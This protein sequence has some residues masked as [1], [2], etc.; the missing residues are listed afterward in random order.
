MAF[1]QDPHAQLPAMPPPPGGIPNFDDPEFTVRSLI[2]SSI[3]F[4]SLAGVTVIVR[5]YT[6]TRIVRAFGSDD[7]EAS[8][9]SCRLEDPGW[10]P[11]GCSSLHTCNGECPRP[12]VILSNA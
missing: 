1:T 8:E 11:L 6:R 2:I 4:T 12:M 5:V 10:Y 7:G 3:I 9:R